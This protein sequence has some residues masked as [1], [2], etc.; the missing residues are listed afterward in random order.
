MH[1]IAS[2]SFLQMGDQN[3][4]SYSRQGAIF[5]FIMH[6]KVMTYALYL[7]SCTLE[8][9]AHSKEKQSY[10]SFETMIHIVS[11]SGAENRAEARSFSIKVSKI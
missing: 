2:I 1:S 5:E 11:I 8:K 6:F 10:T 9:N 7:I 4:D 3:G